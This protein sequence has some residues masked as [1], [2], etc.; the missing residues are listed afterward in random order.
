MSK[1]LVRDLFPT[2]IWICDLDTEEYAPLNA[3]L[4]QSIEA[5]IAP[6]PSLAAGGTWQTDPVLHEL[7]EFAEFTT[8]ARKIV[9]GALDFL[10]VHYRSFQIT[11]CWAN[12]NPLGGLNSSHSHPN[13]Y[14]SGVYYI[15]TP[16]G[17]GRIVFLDPRPQAQVIFPPVDAWS[18]YVGNEIAVDAVEGRFVLFPAWLVHSVPVNRTEAERVSIS[19]NAMFSDFDELS[20]PLWRQGSARVRQQ[21]S[22]RSEP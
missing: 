14:L 6:R 13:N 10:R 2:P 16:P 7:A 21:R 18:K 17:T 22:D 11:G 4:L 8:I 12:I 5:M 19:F 20:R 9:K 15:R 3:R 1:T